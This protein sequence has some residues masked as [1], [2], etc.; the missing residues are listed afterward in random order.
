MQAPLTDI[1]KLAAT[2]VTVLVAIFSFCL[3]LG[4]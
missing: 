2:V 1:V 4:S 3:F